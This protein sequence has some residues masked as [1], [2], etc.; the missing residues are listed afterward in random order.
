VS[1]R[2]STPDEQEIARRIG[3]ISYHRKHTSFNRNAL[4]LID[5]IIFMTSY[6][7]FHLNDGRAL[8]PIA[9]LR[10]EALVEIYHIILIAL[11]A[12]LYWN[13]HYDKR[14]SFWSEL[15]DIVKSLSIFFLLDIALQQAATKSVALQ[16]TALNWV[17]LLVALPAGRWA[18]K[19]AL[20]YAGRWQIPT[21]II[22]NGR[23][24]RITAAALESEKLLGLRVACFLNATSNTS[25]APVITNVTVGSREVHSI[26]GLGSTLPLLRALGQPRILVAVEESE[27]S[28]ARELI[29][30]LSTLPDPIEI[31][32]PLRGLPLYGMDL[33]PL[34]GHDVMLLRARNNLDRRSRYTMKRIFDF[35]TALFLI[36]VLTPLLVFIG[37][38]IRHED[39]GS[40]IFT[41]QRVGFGG[42]TFQCY[43][44]RTMRTNAEEQLAKWEQ[45]G[46]DLWKDYV[47]SNFKLRNDPRVTRIGAWL[48]ATSLDELPQLWNVLRGEMSLVGPRPLLPREV[49]P[50]GKGIRHYI[51]TRPGITG[52]WQISGRSD[53]GFSDRAAFDEWYIKN[54]SLWYDIVT[55]LKTVTVI[56]NRTGAY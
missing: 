14:Q 38:R 53:T 32:P 50:Y 36:A 9:A 20:I 37:W 21:V 24:A 11:M 39:G 43:K 8:D 42:Q 7:F 16:G 28:V 31:A 56:L 35:L 48:R 45:E 6:T 52:V 4:L 49:E 33:V 22:G 5:S 34:F 13:G 2:A 41:Q 55:V 3:D 27:L 46:D 19:S 18:V 26:S 51:R 40:A 30:E 23:N 1:Y 10:G 44:F 17:F 54:W 25:T 12:T 15:K 47:S 29:E